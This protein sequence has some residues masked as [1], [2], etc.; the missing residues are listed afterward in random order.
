MW[1]TILSL[2]LGEATGPV[3]APVAFEPY[4][5]D[6]GDRSAEHFF[7]PKGYLRD[8][9]YP[10]HLRAM[11]EPSLSC[12]QFEGEVYRFLWLRTWGR[13]IAVRVAKSRQNATISAVELDGAGG[14]GPGKVLR[15]T[16]R[17]LSDDEWKSISDGLA[18][19]KFWSMPTEGLD[20]GFDGSRWVLEGRNG[21]RYHVVDR[22][23][24]KAGQYREFC[25]L[26]L[27]LSGFLNPSGTGKREGVY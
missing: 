20:S 11:S 4:R 27:R 19:L 15:R 25:L 14:Y 26:M 24:P 8:V 2:I 3:A 13:P 5:L 22:W 10:E 1:L 23:T 9:W 16:Q 12:W 17:Q 18:A 6:C 7:F 21:S